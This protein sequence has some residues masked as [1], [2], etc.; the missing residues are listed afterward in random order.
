MVRE[1]I[2]ELLPE[3]AILGSFAAA[4]ILVSYAAWNLPLIWDSSIYTAMGKHLFSLGRFGFWEVYRPPGVPVLLGLLWRTSLPVEAFRIVSYGV[5][6]GVLATT[7]RVGSRFWNRRSALVAAA[8]LASSY[9]FVY[10]SAN[11]LT[12]IAAS[13]LLMATLLFASRGKHGTAGLA[14]GAAFVTR[15]PSAIVLPVLIAYYIWSKY[16]E[17]EPRELLESGLKTSTGFAAVSVP[18]LLSSKIFFG[19]FMEPFTT[20]F[21]VTAA[22]GSSYTFGLEYLLIMASNQPLFLLLVPGAV[23]ALRSRKNEHMLVLLAFL[24]FYAFFTYFPLKIQRYTLLFLPLAALLSASAV[25]SAISVLEETL[26]RFPDRSVQLMV[27]GAAAVLMTGF[28]GSVVYDRF[29]YSV[30]EQE[31]FFNE[32]STLNG[33]VASNDPRVNV[34]GDFVYL[35]VPPAKLKSVWRQR[36]RADYWATNSCQWYCSNVGPGCEEDI[37]EFESNLTQFDQLYEAN[38]SQCTYRVYSSK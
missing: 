31:G 17:A 6:L 35:P 13:G 9:T 23:L 3:I 2:R 24:A 12:G 34:E 33:T 20:G 16:P 36:D 7:L 29:D 18:Y 22:A 21:S 10:F 1:R 30:P 32:V 4:G 8:I 37:Q 14:A 27:I 11:P 19:S 28:T 5:S 25:E 15:F 38:S 26:D